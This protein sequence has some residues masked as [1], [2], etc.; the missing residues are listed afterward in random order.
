M[1][2]Q[3]LVYFIFIFIYLSFF[4]QTGGF[5]KGKPQNGKVSMYCPE[6]KESYS[7]NILDLRRYGKGVLIEDG[8][9]YFVEYNE[10]GVEIVENRTRTFEGIR[11]MISKKKL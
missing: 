7:G 4:V 6:K 3:W 1:D 5:Y 2:F 10:N 9:E 11:V 8:K